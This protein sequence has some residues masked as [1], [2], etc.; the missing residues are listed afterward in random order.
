M[1]K[2][3]L[4]IQIGDRYDEAVEVQR[5]LTD[6]GCIIKTRVGLH[7]QEEYKEECTEKGL[8]ILELVKNCGDKGKELEERLNNIEDVKVRKMEF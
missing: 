1:K 4:G 7:Q 8:I 3:I 2:I 5:T 6:F